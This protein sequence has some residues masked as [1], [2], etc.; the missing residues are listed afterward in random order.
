M[1]SNSDLPCPET[2]CSLMPPLADRSQLT[3]AVLDGGV[4]PAA[5]SPGLRQ[6]K[7]WWEWVLRGKANTAQCPGKASKKVKCVYHICAVFKSC[8]WCYFKHPA[9]QSPPPPKPLDN[10]DVYLLL[11]P[12][13][14]FVMGLSSW[15]PSPLIRLPREKGKTKAKKTGVGPQACGWV[16]AHLSYT[17]EH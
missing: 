8:F 12:I 7:S 1:K 2:K 5:E 13:E 11:G 6:S 14:H 10:T 4:F 17:H 9:G 3:A 16:Q 15:L